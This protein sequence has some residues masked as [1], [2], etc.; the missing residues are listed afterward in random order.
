MNEL[1]M[2]KACE[3]DKLINAGYLSD[4]LV[5]IPSSVNKV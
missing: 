5:N 2:F 1:K 4:R 3:T